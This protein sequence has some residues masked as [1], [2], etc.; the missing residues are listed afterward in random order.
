[1]S[2]EL[3]KIG[4]IYVLR[5]PYED[6]VLYD[7]DITL[8]SSASWAAMQPSFTVPSM[9]R[10]VVLARDIAVNR[11]KVLTPVGVGW[12]GPWDMSDLSA[13]HAR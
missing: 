8:W 5:R 9:T 2:P 12:V 6:S 10:C 11:F 7:E 1:M 4:D 3:V 13:S